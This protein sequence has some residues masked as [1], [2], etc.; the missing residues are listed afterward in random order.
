[1]SNPSE[2]VNGLVPAA[3]VLVGLG[4]L[5]A[6]AVIGAVEVWAT[7]VLSFVA[8]AAFT[9]GLL[10]GRLRRRG[11]PGASTLR[12]TEWLLVGILAL[13]LLQ[14][15]PLP[16]ALLRL[17]SPEAALVH[18]RGP[19]PEAG[20]AANP[21]SVY[22]FATKV[23]LIRIAGLVMVFVLFSRLPRRERE[24]RA[25]LALLVGLGGVAALVSLVGYVSG[26]PL[27]DYYPRAARF[28]VRLAGPLVNP[29]H[30]AG[31]LEVLALSGL[32]AFLATAARGAR[33]RTDTL[34]RLLGAALGAGANRGPAVGLLLCVVT[35]TTALFLTGS[36]LGLAAFVAGLAALALL[37]VRGDRPGRA[38]AGL[39]AVAVLL[40]VVNASVAMDPTLE[41]WT[42]FF[43]DQGAARGRLRAAGAAFDMFTFYP[44]VG[45]GL[46]TF[47]HVF[48]GYQPYDVRGTWDHAHNDFLQA[49]ADGG[50]LLGALAAAFLIAWFR[51]IG[52]AVRSLPLS[53]RAVPAGCAAAVV[54]LLVH[55]T[56]DFN[57]QIPLNGYLLAA[58]MG[59]GYGAAALAPTVRTVPQGVRDERHGDGDPRPRS[60]ARDSLRSALRTSEGG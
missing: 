31:F 16:P 23:E 33:S 47:E 5:F 34:P 59:I 42:V 19:S 1:M 9:A 45:S 51:K 10:S 18:S 56:G 3:V 6:T 2:R 35:M 24:T 15:V 14:L 52:A 50:L 17:V 58:V 8:L 43:D 29:N 38:I 32:G 37:L 49:L 28:Q 26:W 13:G 22:P 48:P 27:L 53:S 41:R 54:A 60:H 7:V 25:T 4:A 20:S 21:M 12:S 46:G 11:S 57:L 40:L 39:L 44:L 36:R 30:F 55:G